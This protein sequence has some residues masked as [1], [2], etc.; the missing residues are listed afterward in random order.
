MSPL[1]TILFDP[2]F[3]G[4]WRFYNRV[5]H[6]CPDCLLDEVNRLNSLSCFPRYKVCKVEFL[7]L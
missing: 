1:Y 4:D 5:F 7:D 2:H 3:T 6:V